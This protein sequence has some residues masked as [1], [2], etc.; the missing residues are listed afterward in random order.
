MQAEHAAAIDAVWQR[1]LPAVTQMM[2]AWDLQVATTLPQVEEQF[3]AMLQDCP[4]TDAPESAFGQSFFV[5]LVY[6]ALY[7]VVRDQVDAH[8]LGA[9]MLEQMRQ[10]TPQFDARAK[11]PVTLDLSSPGTHPGEFVAEAVEVEGELGWG[12]N[13]KSCAICHQFGR[14]DA[15]DLV[16]Y[17]CASDD[18][19]SDKGGQG[20][21][22][23]GTIALGAKQCD[24]RY[25]PDH[26]PQ[27]VAQVFPQQIK[28]EH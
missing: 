26:T 21:R 23:S 24:F 3:A 2:Q 12:L 18:V 14:F 1:Q 22:C 15:M 4:Y 11:G 28:F 27:R 9:A 17:M 8:T 19:I 13:I 10:R 20:L 6:L 25:H 16:P 5:C 7:Q